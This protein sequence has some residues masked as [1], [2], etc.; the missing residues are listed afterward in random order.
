MLSTSG[1]KKRGRPKGS[2]N[3]PKATPESGA[4]QPGPGSQPADSAQP[5]PVSPTTSNHINLPNILIPGSQ[6]IIL[7]EQQQSPTSTTLTFVSEQANLARTHHTPSSEPMRPHT[8]QWPSV[9]IQTSERGQQT[10]KAKEKGAARKRKVAEP[11]PNCDIVSTMV[12]NNKSPQLQQ[13]DNTMARG[14]VPEQPAN[15]KR[16]RVSKG[17]TQNPNFSN[18]ESHPPSIGIA[19]SPTLTVANNTVTQI[20]ATSQ[21][22]E[23]QPSGIRQS[24]TRKSPP[25]HFQQPK[26]SLPQLQPLHHKNQPQKHYQF[27][28]PQQP[29]QSVSS[30]HQTSQQQRHQ[31]QQRHQSQGL[32]T[33]SGPPGPRSQAPA[34]GRPQSNMPSQEYYSQQRAIPDQVGQDNSSASG[35][36]R[37]SGVSRPQFTQHAQKRS[38]GDGEAVTI[39]QQNPMVPVGGQHIHDD[40]SRQTSSFTNPHVPSASAPP[41]NVSQFQTY[42]EHSYLDMDYG[43]N[44]RDVQDSATALGD[45]AQ[46]EVVLGEPTMRERLYQT[47]GRR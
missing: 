14:T 36:G 18:M 19:A 20:H 29:Q 5:P 23:H 27:N 42:E 9:G 1:A 12:S 33:P 39:S 41:T 13:E 26:T 21:S 22:L 8:S 38:S 31:H 10:P 30:L 32:S 7:S 2:K 4:T 35:F 25:Q 37:D 40:A 45:P 44:E 11:V 46:L 47:I 17:A 6:A 15:G 34:Y 43:L 28:S 3:R 24:H 16:R